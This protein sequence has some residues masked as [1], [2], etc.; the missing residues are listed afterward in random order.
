MIDLSHISKSYNKGATQAIRDISLH[1]E[2]GEL[3]GLIGPDGA[4]KTTLFQILTTLRLADKGSATV[5]GLDVVKDYRSIRAIIGY[6][7]GRF[8]LYLDL[9]V[10]ENLTFFASLFGTT[11]QSSLELI[12][13][14][15]DQLKPF[16]NRLAGQLSGGMK[17]KLALCCAMIH[18][19]KVLFL[20]EP[21]TG[22]DAVSR[23]EFW[24]MLARLNQ[25]GITIMVSTAY[26]DEAVLCKRVGLIQS[27]NLLSTDS[28]EGIINSFSEPLFAAK[29]ENIRKL[30]KDLRS[31]GKTKSCYPFGEYLHA[32]FKETNLITEVT[33]YLHQL[34]HDHIELKKVKATV[35][36][37]FIRLMES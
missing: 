25:A 3:F 10:K 12:K 36:D 17:Q 31:Y 9:S 24:D 18:S 7:P 19:P 13:D 5:N 23:K 26:M 15:Y 37:S 4:G 1:I 28:P 14:I 29:S 30:L 11:L 16:E 35:E 2:K 33:Q 34:G 6:M 8:S 27:G 22:V 21:T 20:D 32:T